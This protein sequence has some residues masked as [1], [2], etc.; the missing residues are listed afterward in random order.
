[1]T[2][3]VSVPK[4]LVEVTDLY[5]VQNV[6]IAGG[7]SANSSLREKLKEEGKNRGW[8]TFTL[9]FQFCTD[10]AAMIAYLG[11]MKVNEATFS[12]ASHAKPRWPLGS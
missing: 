1:M 11:S 2:F 3:P 9:D 7:V 10:N 8:K 6:A 4:K 5:D 12:L